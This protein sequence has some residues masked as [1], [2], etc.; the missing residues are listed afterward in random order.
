MQEFLC[1]QPSNIEFV[2]CGNREGREVTAMVIQEVTTA[3]LG[4]VPSD[5]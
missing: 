5:V 2:G 1:W 3:G 4:E